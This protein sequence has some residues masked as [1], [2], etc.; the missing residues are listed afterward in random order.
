MSQYT[1]ELHFEMRIV[2]AALLGFKSAAASALYALP[3][4]PLS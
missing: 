1:Q 3:S 2:S 4:I